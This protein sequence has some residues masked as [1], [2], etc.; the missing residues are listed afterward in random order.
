MQSVREFSGLMALGETLRAMVNRS[1]MQD[2]INLD[3]IKPYQLICRGY[4][5]FGFDKKLEI[6]YYLFLHDDKPI[7][8]DDYLNNIYIVLTMWKTSVIISYNGFNVLIPYRTSQ[9][10]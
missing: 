2:R 4:L 3:R 6:S 1:H 5:K 9:S 8:I 10:R 7:L